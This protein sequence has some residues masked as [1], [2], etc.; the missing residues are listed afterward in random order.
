MK[1]VWQAGL[2]HRWSSASRPGVITR[3]QHAAFEGLVVY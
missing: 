3:G 1:T 2:S